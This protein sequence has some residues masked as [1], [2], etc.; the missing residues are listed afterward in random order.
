MLSLFRTAA[1]MLLS[2]S[3]LTGVVYPLAVTL[4]A[5]TV[6]PEQSGGSVQLDD[7]RSVGSRV[8]GQSTSDPSLFWWR[9][10][11]TAPLAANAMAGSGSNL[12]Q[13]NPALREA[14]RPRCVELRR[15]DPENRAPIPID[16][17]VASASG[18]D[19]HVSPAA[20]L[21]QVDRVARANRLDRETVLKLVSQCIEPPTVGVFGQA[22]VNVLRL[23][24]A[25]RAELRHRENLQE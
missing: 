8:L 22:R 17:V 16:L 13:T 4:A 18:L 14:V 23:N 1:R 3:L 24:L 15:L 7:N 21:F 20:G 25:L 6:F 11:A 12:A 2:L 19:P 9:P 10:S 5:K